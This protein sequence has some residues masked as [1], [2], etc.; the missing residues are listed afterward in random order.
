MVYSD[1]NT[2]INTPRKTTYTG[3]VIKNERMT[4]DIHFQDVRELEIQCDNPNFKYEAGHVLVVQPKNT[5]SRV[6]EVIDYFQWNDVA[7]KTF[8]LESNYSGMY[9]FITH[10]IL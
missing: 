9:Q 2:N 10:F 7:D 4:S 6:Q 8:V 5:D 1:S 3:L